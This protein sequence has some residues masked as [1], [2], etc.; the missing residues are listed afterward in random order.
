[1]QQGVPR[2]GERSQLR[3]ALDQLDAGDVPMV[4][5]LARSTRDL[6]NT[7]ASITE[8]RAIRATSAPQM[9]T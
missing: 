7:L 4:M 2:D 6:R 5:R 8:K 1:M 3:K 9:S